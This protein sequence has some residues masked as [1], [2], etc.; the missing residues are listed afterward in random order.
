M[1]RRNC[2]VTKGDIVWARV[3]FPR[4]IW[5]AL[6]LTTDSLGVCVSFFNHNLSPRYVIESETVP[7]EEG[8][9]WIMGCQKGVIK[10]ETFYGLLDSAL[11]LMGQR[12]VSSL[13]CRCLM[14]PQ[15]NYD[16]RERCDGSKSNA[17][18]QPV[19]VLGFVLRVAVVPW[20]DELDSV[21]AVRAVAQVQAFRG[22]C[23]IEQKR[24]YEETR[25]GG[26]DVKPLRCSSSDVEKHYLTQESDA[27]EPRHECQILSKE[28]KKTLTLVKEKVKPL[29]KNQRQIIPQTHTR[30]W[31]AELLPEISLHLR[32]LTFDPFYWMREGLRY[33]KLRLLRVDNISDHKIADSYFKDCSKLSEAFSRRKDTAIELHHSLPNI[34]TTYCLTKKRKQPDHHVLCDCSFK[35]QKLS[36]RS[37]TN[38]EFSFLK[39]IVSGRNKDDSNVFV[40]PSTLAGCIPSFRMEMDSYPASILQHLIKLSDLCCDNASCCMSL[41]KDTPFHLDFPGEERV[42][43]TEGN[44]CI[45]EYSRPCISQTKMFEPGKSIQKHSQSSTC[46]HETAVKFTEEVDL[47][48]SSNFVLSAPNSCDYEVAAKEASSKVLK[49]SDISLDNQK[50][51]ISASKK[52]GRVKLSSRGCLK[53]NENLDQFDTSVDSKVGE[54]SKT[55]V[56]HTCSK[57]LHMKFPENVNL[58][59]KSELIK[60]FRVFGYVDYLKTKVFSFAGSARVSFLREADAV[61]AYFHAKRKKICFGSGNVRFWLDPFEHKRGGSSK[62]RLP[63][64]PSVR[65]QPKPLK[66]CLRSSSSEEKDKRKKPYKVRFTIV[67]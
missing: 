48:S 40:L 23:S 16:G 21:D 49:G 19:G 14:N 37:S 7:F 5:P 10:C 62:Y 46:F 20:V 52:S 28:V 36:S 65:E 35:L 1:K 18:F 39:M 25:G 38:E 63:V 33:V 42:Q 57:S 24:V 67:T 44:D 41:F 13:K 54:K 17:C 58:P 53:K 11:K 3:Q 51:Q 56:S 64:S 26:N 43:E 15:R 59:S 9:G 45:L 22:Y 66:S 6:V 2:S 31:K 47:E 30:N 50:L 61:T 8:F 27:L 4:Q 60:K 29:H 12:V 32:S 34:K 55:Q